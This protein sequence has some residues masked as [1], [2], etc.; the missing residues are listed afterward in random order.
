MIQF[1][2]K[3]KKTSSDSKRHFTIVIGSKEHGLYI[4][5][6]PSS[7]AKK[8]VT[9]LCASNKSKKVEFH[10][11][12]ITLGS[13]KKTYGPYDGYIEI[14]KEPIELKGRVIKYKSV[15]KLR[16]KSGGGEGNLRKRFPYTALMNK[17]VNDKNV[18]DYYPPPHPHI[19]RNKL[20]KSIFLN[21]N[22]LKQFITKHYPK[23]IDDIFDYLY[24][25]NGFHADLIF[26]NKHNT[27]REINK[28]E[29]KS[30][31]N[32][33]INP[34]LELQSKTNDFFI[35]HPELSENEKKFVQD[36]IKI[37]FSKFSSGFFD[38][39]P[40]TKNTSKKT[41]LDNKNYQIDEARK[42]ELEQL[43]LKE[44]YNKFD[45]RKN[46]FKKKV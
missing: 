32:M 22:R 37:P 1:G 13:K 9:K 31:L 30:L 39:V 40:W 5:S 11:R 10:M 43:L 42:K 28:E 20:N 29:L 15:A 25:S 41:V 7:A 19:S 12:E 33:Y 14:L 4:S 36:Y 18:N 34:F 17:N 24:E 44:I 23:E 2:G 45:A 35:S 38:N 3:P 26:L 46:H 21:K 27:S 8:A 6:T 16:K